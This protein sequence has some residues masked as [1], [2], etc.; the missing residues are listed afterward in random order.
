MNWNGSGLLEL[1]KNNLFPAMRSAGITNTEVLALDYNWGT[2]TGRRRWSRTT[3]PEHG[4]R[5][6]CAA[7]VVHRR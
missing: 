6:A 7:V 3:T 5:D 4:E 1:T 2:R